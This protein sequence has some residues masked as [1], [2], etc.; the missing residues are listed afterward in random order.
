MPIKKFLS[1]ILVLLFVSVTFSNKA[2]D[3]DIQIE[4][5][6]R[7]LLIEYTSTGCPGCGGWGN[8][9]FKQL[10]KQ[11]DG[12]VSPMAAHIKY[13]DPMINKISEQLADNRS[14]RK[15]TPQIAV[16]RENAVVIK[17]SIDH[18]ASM[19]K[20]SRLVN[21]YSAISAPYLG[22]E[23]SIRGDQLHFN[24]LI[25]LS[26]YSGNLE[27]IKIAVYLLE[28]QL[29]HKQAGAEKSNEVHSHV[30]K[31]AFTKDAFGENLSQM[32]INQAKQIKYQGSF[33][34]KASETNPKN[35]EV[36]VVIWKKEEDGFSPINS[37]PLP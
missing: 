16:N 23:T 31:A 20:V 33:D 25:D 9:T 17:G 12:K 36:T 24:S 34:L 14:G 15:Y 27:E 3:E 2:V 22:G 5:K 8:P 19:K 13:G 29:I 35:A 10:S 32:T 26:S 21:Q 4:K 7:P 30:I 18:R 37:L 1:I 11:Y 28:N 6:I